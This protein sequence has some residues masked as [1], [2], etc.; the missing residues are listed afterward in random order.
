MQILYHKEREKEK[1]RS[2]NRRVMR[3]AVFL[4]FVLFVWPHTAYAA[5]IRQIKAVKLIQSQSDIH[6]DPFAR[7]TVTVGFKNIGT[8]AWRSED[9]TLEIRASVKG[10]SYLRASAWRSGNRVKKI[11]SQP[12]PGELAY[13]T[14]DIEAPKKEGTFRETFALYAAGKKITGT[15]ARFTVTVSGHRKEKG[16]SF[17]APISKNAPNQ[18]ASAEQ[19]Q[20]YVSVPS[21]HA[22]RLIQSAQFLTLSQYQTAVF[23]VGY[24]NT[25]TT[26]WTTDTVPALTLRSLVKKE[27]YFH[28]VSWISPN[29]IAGLSQNVEPGQIGYFTFVLEAPY[30]TGDYQERLALFADDMKISGT[31]FSIPITVTKAPAALA[32][33]TPFLQTQREDQ[34]QSQYALAPPDGYVRP[35]IIDDMQEQEQN[36]RVGITYTRDP[37]QITANAPYEIRDGTG[38]RMSVEET[39]SVSTVTFDFSTKIYSALT[40][41]GVFVSQSL[42][43]FLGAQSAQ[44]NGKLIAA[45]I[46]NEQAT[47]TSPQNVSS[48]FSSM[49]EQTPPDQDVIFEILSFSNRPSWS[50]SLNDNKYRAML[51]IRYTSSTDKLWIVNDLPL[52]QYLRGIAETS[53]NAPYEYQKTMTIAARTYAKYHI[54]RSTKYADE[55]FTVRTTDA[56]QVYRG[57]NSEIRLP[58]VSQAVLETRGVM[59]FYN[60]MLAITPYYSQSD[61]RTRSWEEVWAGGP[62]PW[63]VSKD[64]P[65][66][67]GLPLLGHG[68]G[69]SA[70][71]AVAMALEGKTAE[72][73]L[74]YYYTGVE[75]R[76]RY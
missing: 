4:S 71:G 39:G 54:A 23:T 58:K 27:S 70:R 43:R 13:V 67:K 66:C 60:N 68:V 59:V 53:N 31:D 44:N 19:R 15:D 36:I 47:S 22:L 42:F 20:Q 52:E 61:G 62:K 45:A 73:I 8:R 24:K 11:F 16:V 18:I 40:P 33:S 41:K 25:G 2:T 50:S 3:Y 51:E 35:G 7:T 74:K 9:G 55:Q 37:I 75:L 1:G 69:I 56:D 48:T 21:I 6:L 5:S 46:E 64:D 17:S 72:E 49:G 29:S 76:K 26:I 32:I 28:H 57:Y 10:E 65:A 38:A 14:F 63:L 30:A 12:K 34:S